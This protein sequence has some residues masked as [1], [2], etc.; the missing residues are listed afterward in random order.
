MFKATKQEVKYLHRLRQD[1]MFVSSLCITHLVIL[2]K[3]KK[4]L[5]Q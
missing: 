1:H 4:I 3:G 2:R 5:K